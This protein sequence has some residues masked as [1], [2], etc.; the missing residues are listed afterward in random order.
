[1]SSSSY[2]VHRDESIF[3][4]ADKFDPER[5]IRAKNEGKNLSRYLVSFTRGSRTCIGMK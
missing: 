4:D 5:W 2:I 1:M 3:P